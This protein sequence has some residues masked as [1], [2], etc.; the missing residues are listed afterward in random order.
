MAVKSNDINLCFKLWAP[1]GIPA[2]WPVLITALTLLEV[3]FSRYC[4]VWAEWW[5][6]LVHFSSLDWTK[7]TF[8]GI[9]GVEDKRKLMWNQ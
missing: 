1:S 4:E 2:N 3:G 7:V 5:K 6:Y 8:S 9:A